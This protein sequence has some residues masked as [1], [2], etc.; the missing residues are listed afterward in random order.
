MPSASTN[1]GTSP[2]LPA[3][4]A[5][6]K[7][8]PAAADAAAETVMGVWIP[9]RA[10][11]ERIPARARLSTS[12]RGLHGGGHGEVLAIE[13]D[14]ARPGVAG[15]LVG[16]VL[17]VEARRRQEPVPQARVDLVLE[18]DAAL[19][20]GPRVLLDVV[21]P[22]AGVLV[23]PEREDGSLDLVDLL[24]RRDWPAA[25]LLGGAGREAVEAHRRQ[26]VPLGGQVEHPRAA[27]AEADRA[28]SIA[29]HAG[30]LTQPVERLV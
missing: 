12:T 11:R 22:H 9:L 21:H 3:C 26:V 20:E 6:L 17:G 28:Q 13:V 8:N 24:Q 27:H 14:G 25:R 5:M 4:S 7:F 15:L 19:L 18:V 29:A 10:V 1:L 16:R 30:L 23:A 2:S